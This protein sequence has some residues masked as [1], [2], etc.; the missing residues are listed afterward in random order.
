MLAVFRAWTSSA[1]HVSVTFALEWAW[2]DELGRETLRPIW[3]AFF[4]PEE[5]AEADRSVNL[6]VRASLI[7]GSYV[8]CDVV[9]KSPRRQ[10]LLCVVCA[11]NVCS[12]SIVSAH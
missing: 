3:V 10:D 12:Y 1:H 11:H 2:S 4:L 6:C 5:H 9:A 8:L 7:T